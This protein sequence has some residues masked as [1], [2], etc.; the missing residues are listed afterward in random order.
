[1]KHV[2]FILKFLILRKQTQSIPRIKPKHIHC[3][4][5][6]TNTLPCFKQVRFGHHAAGVE[7]QQRF[8]TKIRTKILH[9]TS[10]GDPTIRIRLRTNK[11][12]SLLAHSI[13]LA[14]HCN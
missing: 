3:E 6:L 2:Y 9:W 5:I 14:M 4:V 1:M 12:S 10:N 7:D 13:T 8:V 11:N